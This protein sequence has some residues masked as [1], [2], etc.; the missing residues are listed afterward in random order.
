MR[1]SAETPLRRR[2]TLQPR[3]NFITQGRKRGTRARVG[4]DAVPFG[5]AVQFREDG[6]QIVSQTFALDGRQRFDGSFNFGNRAHL[7][8]NLVRRGRVVK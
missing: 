6:R 8:G 5:I 7:A 2:R 4:D 1:R 3:G